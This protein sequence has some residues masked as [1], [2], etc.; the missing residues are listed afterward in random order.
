MTEPYQPID[1][2]FFAFHWFEQPSPLCSDHCCFSRSLL[3]L[4][5]ELDRLNCHFSAGEKTNAWLT[6]KIISLHPFPISALILSHILTDG[7]DKSTI[8]LTDSDYSQVGKPRGV[9]GTHTLPSAHQ[10]THPHPHLPTHSEISGLVP[11]A[12]TLTANSRPGT[13]ME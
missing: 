2:S 5:K 8:L 4:E 6:R 12:P 7:D 13:S 11:T 3:A 10:H 1:L 9:S